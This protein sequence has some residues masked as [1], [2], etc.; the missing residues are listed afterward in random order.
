MESV[1]AFIT[2]VRENYQSTG[3]LLKTK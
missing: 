1:K 2:Q 3:D